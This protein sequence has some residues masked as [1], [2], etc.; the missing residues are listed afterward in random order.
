MDKNKTKIS[1]IGKSWIFVA[2]I[3]VITGV[4]LVLSITS[5]N[6]ISTSSPLKETEVDPAQTS[7]YF[8]DS[9]R[10]SSASG[11]YDMDINIDTNQDKVT[12]VQLELSYDPK[13]LVRVDIQPGSFINNSV[14]VQKNVDPFN[15]R[16]KYWLGTQPNQ[17]GIKGKGVVATITFV[18]IGS[19]SAQIIFLPKTSVSASGTNESVLK[20]MTPGI[21][22]IL[23]Q[24][25]RKFPIVSPTKTP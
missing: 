22:N 21:I 18:K 14:I 5:K 4:L 13:Q 23:P 11:T 2:A 3:V 19:G 24:P 25:I 20:T 16:I 9:P 6:H 15:G 17:T 12:L 8:S 10:I 1:K 7:L